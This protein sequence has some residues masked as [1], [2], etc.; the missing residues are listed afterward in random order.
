MPAGAGSGSGCPDGDIT[1]TDV[2][3][4]VDASSAG[5]CQRVRSYGS[6]AQRLLLP[7]GRK[8]TQFSAF[9]LRE[10]IA[11]TRFIVVGRKLL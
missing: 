1:A 4:A 3:A 6:S 9:L 2:L 10:S 5:H 11:V 7:L 8:E